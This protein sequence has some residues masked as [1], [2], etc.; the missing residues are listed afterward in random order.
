MSATI[1][2]DPAAPVSERFGGRFLTGE[3]A[4][5]L[6]I[7]KSGD[8][9]FVEM[10]LRFIDVAASGFPGKEEQPWLAEIADMTLEQLAAMIVFADG[11]RIDAEQR[12]EWAESIEGAA[13]RLY[14]LSV[15]GQGV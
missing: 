6:D 2:I 14:Y 8:I 15:E 11:I 13:R 9:E 4:R 5:R 1:E 12:L 10:N 3:E 7:G